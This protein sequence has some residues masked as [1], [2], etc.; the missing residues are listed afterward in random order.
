[1]NKASAGS[2]PFSFKRRAGDEFISLTITAEISPYVG[3]EKY[4]ER[5]SNV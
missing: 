2:S 3:M 1:M 5:K 4:T